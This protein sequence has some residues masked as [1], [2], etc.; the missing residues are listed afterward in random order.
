MFNSCVDIYITPI[1]VSID[2][3]D[4]FLRPDETWDR[5]VWG[6]INQGRR[7]LAAV[8][9]RD[10]TFE[11]LAGLI[12][13][14]QSST[15]AWKKGSRP[16]RET[17]DALE[18]V[19]L[20]A[21]LVQFTA[22]FLDYGPNL[23]DSEAEYRDGLQQAAGEAAQTARAEEGR[24]AAELLNRPRPRRVAEAPP[25]PRSPTP[26]KGARKKPKPEA[27]QAG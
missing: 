22:R 7:E 6:R 13:R 10:I 4:D 14:R 18:R 27:D 19:F 25:I 16:T 11:R 21:G 24:E 5:T 17:L 3:L 9:A 12:G 20:A 1:G 15:S 26:G 2:N 8:L 23:A